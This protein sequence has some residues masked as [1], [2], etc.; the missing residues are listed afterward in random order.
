MKPG[1]MTESNIFQ[2]VDEHLPFIM[3]P[4]ID[5]VLFGADSNKDWARLISPHCTG[6]VDWMGEFNQSAYCTDGLT[7]LRCKSRCVYSK[8]QT[9]R[10][11]CHV[12]DLR[13][14][15]M[16]SELEWW[17]CWKILSHDLVDKY[18]TNWAL[19]R[20]VS[21]RSVSSFHFPRQFQIDWSID[22]FLQRS[23]LP[24]IRLLIFSTLKR[25]SF[26]P[27]L[28]RIDIDQIKWIQKSFPS[29]FSLGSI[30]C[31]FDSDE[32]K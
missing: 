19:F 27:F 18:R 32:W 6:N 23:Q 24:D 4:C 1:R 31:K 20:T 17:S 29:R 26:L 25:S 22:I 8:I 28:E 16:L 3:A 30:D 13:F 12:G 11:L 9:D 15:S 21:S 10:S 2:S 14:G 5:N 7:T